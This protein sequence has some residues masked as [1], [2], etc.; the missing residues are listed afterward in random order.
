MRIAPGGA[1]LLL[2][3]DLVVAGGKEAL[4]T[5]APE[6]GHAVVNTHE[7]MTGDFTRNAD[8]STCRRRRCARRSSRPRA[9]APASSDATRLATAL[10]GDAIATNLF[11]VGF[12]YQQ[13]LLPVSAAAIERAI[14]LNRVAVAMNQARVPLG[15]P[16][17]ARSRRGRGGGGAGSSIGRCA[18]CR[19]AWTS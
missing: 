19:R 17:G 9:S 16:R 15:P 14:E 4:A 10:L 12:A 3:C 7:M 1:R 6:R 5:L 11:M 8:F 2:G 18:A 13:G